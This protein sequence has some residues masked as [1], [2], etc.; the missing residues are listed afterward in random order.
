VV[1]RDELDEYE[2]LVDNEELVVTDLLD[3]RELSDGD[4]LADCTAE[5][6]VTWF[7]DT[8]LVYSGN[9]NGDEVDVRELRIAGA[10]LDDPERD[11]DAD[12]TDD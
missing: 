2:L 8:R 3:E 12:G 11:D 5:R 9:G 1:E 4:E 7:D 10:L 6:D